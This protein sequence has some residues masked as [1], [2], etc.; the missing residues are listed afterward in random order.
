MLAVSAVFGLPASVW[1]YALVPIGTPAKPTAAHTDRYQP[2]RIHYNKYGSSK[3]SCCFLVIPMLY[4]ACVQSISYKM[5]GV[6][7]RQNS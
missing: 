2:E 1:P 6:T 7:L 3:Q 5:Q 4:F